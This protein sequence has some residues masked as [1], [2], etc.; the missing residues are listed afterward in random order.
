MLM[1]PQKL[2]EPMLK[3]GFT[4]AGS[5][6]SSSQVRDAVCIFYLVL[7]T[8]PSEGCDPSDPSQQLAEKLARQWCNHFHQQHLWPSE[9]GLLRALG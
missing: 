4:M 2:A 5:P 6:H 7:Q 9:A 1:E 8:G 3:N